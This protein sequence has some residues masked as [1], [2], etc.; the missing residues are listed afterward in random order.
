MRLGSKGNVPYRAM[1]HECWEWVLSDGH[2]E[3]WYFVLAVMH[4]TRHAGHADLKILRLVRYYYTCNQ[5]L[6]DHIDPVLRIK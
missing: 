3:G 4:V 6:Q 2:W 1:H 5:A